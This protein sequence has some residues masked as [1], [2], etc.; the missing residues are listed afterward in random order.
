[1]SGLKTIRLSHFRFGRFADKLSQLHP[2]NG[3]RWVLLHVGTKRP[4][5]DPRSPKNQVRKSPLQIAVV[6]CSGPK[7]ETLVE[8]LLR[9]EVPSVLIQSWTIF[10]W[11]LWHVVS[12]HDQTLDCVLIQALTNGDEG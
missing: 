5:L 2:W 10:K 12:D 9:D 7:N 6:I 4:V 3:V 11:W 1:V 8:R